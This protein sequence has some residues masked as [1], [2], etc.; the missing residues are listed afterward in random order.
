MFP[1][2]LSF[3]VLFPFPLFYYWNQEYSHLHGNHFIDLQL[4]FLFFFLPS[5][6]PFFC[7]SL[8]LSLFSFVCLFVSLIFVPFLFV[9]LFFVFT[10]ES[11]EFW[12]SLSTG[13]YSRRGWCACKL[14][15][16]LVLSLPSSPSSSPKQLGYETLQLLK[17]T[18]K[19][20]TFIFE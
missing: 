1:Y 14:S 20:K 17:F 18:S 4:L 10:Q 5:F 13:H 3:F 16:M 2:F 8:F 9:C 11:V 12:R 19:W 7:H 6:L 15:L